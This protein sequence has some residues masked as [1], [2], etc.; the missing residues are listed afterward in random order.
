[1]VDQYGFFLDLDLVDLEGGLI[2]DGAWVLM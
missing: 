1:M 2:V